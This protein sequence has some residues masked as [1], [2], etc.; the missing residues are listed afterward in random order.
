MSASTTYQPISVEDRRSGSA[1][2]IFYREAGT[3]DA[4]VVLL[5]HGLAAGAKTLVN[6]VTHLARPALDAGFRAA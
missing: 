5:L 4:P 1:L 3:K 6:T 2:N